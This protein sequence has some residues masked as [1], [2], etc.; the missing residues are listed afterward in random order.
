MGNEQ[1]RERDGP[2]PRAKAIGDA[3]V[4]FV[5]AIEPLDE[6]FIMTIF[7]RLAV[8]ILQTNDLVMNKGLTVSLR[9]TLGID[10]MERIGISGVAVCNVGDDLLG[11]GGACRFL[12][13]N[14]R[15]QGAARIGEV[16]SDNLPAAFGEKEKDEAVFTAN[17]DVGFIASQSRIEG[18]LVREIEVMAVKSRGFSIIEHGLIRNDDTKEL[19]EHERGFARADRKGNIERENQAHQMRRLMNAVQ[20]DACGTGRRV[21]EMFFGVMMLAVLIV[22]FELRQT[23]RLQLLFFR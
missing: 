10:K 23:L 13:G 11:I 15:G 12:H 3:D 16:I 9:A 18:S 22:Q 20:R 5:S 6:L 1:R 17:F 2:I 19:P 21:A 8:E 7:F 4:M 14:R